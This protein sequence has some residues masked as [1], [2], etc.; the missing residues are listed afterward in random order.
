MKIDSNLNQ[1]LSVYGLNKPVKESR[2]Q[3]HVSPDRS[4]EIAQKKTPAAESGKK[5]EKTQLSFSIPETV[6]SKALSAEEKEFISAMFKSQ[7]A[8]THQGYG[9]NSRNINPGSLGQNIDV[10]A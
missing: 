8:E 6:L 7:D 3:E 2:N 9:R 5:T 4:Q 1:A 10:T